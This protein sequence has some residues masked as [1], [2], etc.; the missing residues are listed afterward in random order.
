MIQPTIPQ[1]FQCVYIILKQPS[2]DGCALYGRSC[3][4][5]PMDESIGKSKNKS[6]YF[7]IENDSACWHY[8]LGKSYCNLGYCSPKT[9]QEGNS[10]KG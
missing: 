1:K 10:K 8:S 9:S 2:T 5:S 4:T 7:V 3:L 6:S